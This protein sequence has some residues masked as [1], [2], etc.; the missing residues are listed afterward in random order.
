MEKIVNPCV[1][2]AFA[3]LVF[4]MAATGYTAPPRPPIV[5]T[6]ACGPCAGW[7]DYGHRL[8]VCPSA[9]PL[10]DAWFACVEGP[11]ATECSA[12]IAAY[13][14]CVT[15]GDPS[16]EM[17]DDSTCNA[18][19]TRPDAQGGCRTETDDCG[20]DTTG[21]VTC[22]EWLTGGD[23]QWL[24]PYASIGAAEALSECACGD[25]GA[26][27]KGQCSTGAYVP[28]TSPACDACVWSTCSAQGSACAAD[29]VT[30]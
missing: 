16:C 30:M 27:C 28:S 14:A 5:V 21:C 10:L 22:G 8:T 1:V 25:C 29:M 2:A 26:A 12:W 4:P 17:I 19:I 24:C 7:W 18:C 13:D 20:A 23:P 3:L 15:S 11:C 6:T 9:E